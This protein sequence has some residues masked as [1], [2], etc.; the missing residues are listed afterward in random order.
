MRIMSLYPTTLT[1]A[2]LAAGALWALPAAGQAP[3][4]RDTVR[5]AEAVV[6]TARP[7]P[8]VAA[9]R[10]G[11]GERVVA[12]GK[13]LGNQNNAVTVVLERA[14][15]PDEADYDTWPVQTRWAIRAPDSRKSFVAE[16]YGRASGSHETHLSGIIT[17]GYRKGQEVRV[18]A[19]LGLEHQ[20]TILIGT[21][22][23]IQ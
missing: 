20:T 21:P 10:P 8:A 13:M 23:G 12:Q 1:A 2:A 19:P 17:D 22:R 16:L 14:G 5:I 6:V 18:E 15:T 7:D 9:A 4:A 3:V 11:A